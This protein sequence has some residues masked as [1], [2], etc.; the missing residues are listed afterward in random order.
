MFF[1]KNGWIKWK[2][3]SRT[4]DIYL[5]TLIVRVNEQRSNWARKISW[6]WLRMNS[7]KIKN[8]R[9]SRGFARYETY[10]CSIK[11][12]I[13]RGSFRLIEKSISKI[14]SFIHPRFFLIIS[15]RVS[16]FSSCS[17]L[18]KCNIR[19]NTVIYCRHTIFS[20]R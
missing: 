1:A 15:C 18:K 17:F 19:R 14:A 16:T 4:D 12:D 11:R 8:V 3:S 2:S 20:S 7:A 13:G 5:V 9:G 10:F 6:I